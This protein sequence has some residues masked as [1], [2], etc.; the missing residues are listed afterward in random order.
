MERK[1][2]SGAIRNTERSKK[3]FLDAVGTILKTTGYADLKINKIA[4]VAGL[5]KKM[6]YKYFGSTDQLIDEYIQSQDF[7][8]NVKNELQPSEL[9]NGG[10]AFVEEALHA[11]FDFV[12]KNK[13]LQK[14]L[15]WRLSEERQT[16]KKLTDDQEQNG[17]QLFQ[18]VASPHFKENERQFRAIMA[19]M[20]SGLYYLNLFSAV[21]S[22][23]FCGLDL[24]NEDDRQEIN[25]AISF[26]IEE[27]YKSL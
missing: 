22:S 26:L 27:T 24:K 7:W 16:L 3:K 17:E 23:V 25:R 1:T 10:K 4:A 5:D 20:V 15:L 11:Q 13:E 12:F 18:K 8:S 6:I 2:A 9:K 19:I 21:N 14:V